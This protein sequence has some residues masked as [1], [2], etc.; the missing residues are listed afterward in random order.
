MRSIFVL[1][2]DES[3]GEIFG[4]QRDMATHSVTALE[5]IRDGGDGVIIADVRV[6]YGAWEFL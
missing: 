1:E 3:S 6:Q 4:D 2:V 5:G